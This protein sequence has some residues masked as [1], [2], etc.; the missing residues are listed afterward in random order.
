M[1]APARLLIVRHGESTWNAENRLQGHADPPLSEAGRGQAAALRPYL[2]G[3]PADRVRCSSSL[4]AR[5]TAELAGHPGLAGDDR[6]REVGSGAWEGRLMA[7]LP[8]DM[9]EPAWRAGPFVPPG[10]ESWDQMVERSAAAFAE[11]LDAGG[12]WLVFCHGGVVRG[13]VQRL[14]GLAPTHMLAPRNGSVTVL[15][16]TR[17]VAYSWTPDGVPGMP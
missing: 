16:R 4:R 9:P 2:G 1:P 15:E 10:G 13:A 12:A 3:F 17:L 11:L 7:D 5:Q 14:T 6:L 8:P